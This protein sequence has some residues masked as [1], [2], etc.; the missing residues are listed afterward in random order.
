MSADD[1][2]AAAFAL[3]ENFASEEVDNGEAGEDDHKNDGG[4]LHFVKVV[5]DLT[6]FRVS[7]GVDDGRDYHEHK[8][9]AEG[10]D[11]AKNGEAFEAA[12]LGLAAKLV[13]FTGAFLPARGVI[14]F[15]HYLLIVISIYYN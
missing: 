12:G 13:E 7:M 8:R 6:T 1:G 9:A 15:F 2:F 14:P 10:I 4:E 5:V 3:L 11:A